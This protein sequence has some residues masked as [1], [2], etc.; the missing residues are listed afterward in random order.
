MTL[1]KLGI[2]PVLAIYLLTGCQESMIDNQNIETV[3]ESNSITGFSAVSGEGETVYPMKIS[4]RGVVAVSPPGENDYTNT[5]YRA[6]IEDG[7]MDDI[8][9]EPF[10]Y[11]PLYT[12]LA[13]T[14][15]DINQLYNYVPSSNS[16]ACVYIDNPVDSRIMFYVQNQNSS[17]QVDMEVYWDE[18]A[19]HSLA[20]IRESK[21]V[22]EP[23]EWIT[24]HAEAGHFYFQMTGKIGDGG[25]I[26]FA[27]AV[28]T[29]IDEFEPNDDFQQAYEMPGTVNNITSN[30]DDQQDVDYYR[31]EAKRGE[32]VQLRLEDPF[33]LNEFQLEVLG[34]NGWQALNTDVNY[35]LDLSTPYQKIN[36]RVRPRDGVT[37]NTTH[38]YR[39]AIGSAVR[40]IDAEATTS[41]NLPRMRYVP[42]ATYYTTQVHNEL[43]WSMRIVDSTNAGVEG[44]PVTF[45]FRAQEIPSRSQTA[46][47]DWSGLVSGSFILPDCTGNYFGVARRESERW[48]TEFD[49]GLW[50]ATTPIKDLGVG[51]DK[52][53]YV[54]LAHICKQT[55]Q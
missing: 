24:Y 6:Q 32:D 33:G 47:T 15:I 52:V 28:N 36:V 5:E 17:R 10:I 53:P 9:I 22:L 50:K 2:L 21:D 4:E 11:N 3:G 20:M 19:D 25:Q 14:R 44:I 30:L 31:F 40:V 45:I 13:C 18:N 8:G 26:Q 27:A 23:A 41:E 37:V 42:G 7:S 39:L 46:V 43:D 16:V 34:S 29:N 35:E 55:L 38:T 1:R 12:P 54:T 48:L 49:T 51:G